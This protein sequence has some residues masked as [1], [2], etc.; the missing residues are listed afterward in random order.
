MSRWRLLACSITADAPPPA[1]MRQ[2]R[3]AQ[4]VDGPASGVSAERR[5]CGAVT[6]P[7]QAGRAAEISPG[8]GGGEE[9]RPAVPACEVTTEQTRCG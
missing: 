9:Q 3:V 1:K 8:V 2:R 7:G 4:L 6:E 5:R